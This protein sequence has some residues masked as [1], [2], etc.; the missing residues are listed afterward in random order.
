MSEKVINSFQLRRQL[1]DDIASLG[2]TQTEAELLARVRQIVQDY[3]AA[4]ILAAFRRFLDTSSSQLRGG[5]G[6]LATLLPHQEIVS[7]LR[8][9][10]ANRQNPTPVRLTAALILERF[11]QVE[12]SPGLMGDLQDPEV[13]IMQ[14]LQEALQESQENP[15]VL[16]EYV[17]Q[18]RQESDGVAFMVM[19]LLEKLEPADRVELLRLIAYDG[20]VQVARSAL[21]R[22]ASMD[23]GPAAPLAAAA[24]RSL[25]Y[26][27]SPQL[28][29]EAERAARKLHFRGVTP[30]VEDDSGWRALITPCSLD[31]SQDLWFI[32]EADEAQKRLLLGLRI[33]ATAGLLDGFGSHGMEPEHLP[34]RRQIGDLLT[35]SLAQGA[36]AAFL[37]IPMAYARWRLRQTL[38]TH[39]TQSQPRPLPEEYTLY[40]RSLWQTTPPSPPEDVYALLT[41]GPALWQGEHLPLEEASATL[42]RHP[43]MAGWFIQNQRMADALADTP[44]TDQESYDRVRQELLAAL[45]PPE[46]D[47]TFGAELQAALLAQA[48]WLHL[49]GHRRHATHAVLLAESFNRIPVSAHPFPALMVEIGLLLLLNYGE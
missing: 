9:E 5:L 21:R 38:T 48:A 27:L 25:Q 43:A 35:I 39:W 46:L 18:M 16:L 36:A 23:A 28:G 26:N 7:L 29:Q 10:A 20:R 41:S 2:E 40:N 8:K 32:H 42:L 12:L 37:E 3:D 14:S 44:V 15:Y 33:N 19:D 13:V 6:R 4:M 1:N 22:L 34:P 45:F 31:G 24:L 17:R 11:L 49:A 47:E 30:A